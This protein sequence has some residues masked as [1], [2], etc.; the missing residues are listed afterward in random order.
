MS[1]DLLI[2]AFTDQPLPAFTISVA[3]FAAFLMGFARSGIGAGGFV[4]SPLMVL[5]LGGSDGLA[6]VAIL[7]LPAAVMGFWQHKGEAAPNQLR[8]LIAASV[9]GTTLG[10]L[11]LWHLV[12][13]GDMALIHRRLEVVVA[14]LSLTFVVLISLREKIAKLAVNL[15]SPSQMSLF[16]MGTAVGVSQTVSNSG[17]PLITVYF[18][19]YR[20]ARQHFV[21]AQVTYLLVQNSVKVVPLI[22]LGIL[23]LGNAGAA[24]LLIPLTLAGSWLG[25]RFFVK[26][27]DRAFFRLYLGLLIIGLTASVLLL[28][29]RDPVIHAIESLTTHS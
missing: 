25:Q 14:A 8:P 22:L 9:I 5:A 20:I 23:H 19:C 1:F 2:A 15:A 28:I 3:I 10:A 29:G 13:D 11:I 17:S 7:M 21:G 26:A 4:V 18:L 16:M 27:S 24:I 6:V 12:A